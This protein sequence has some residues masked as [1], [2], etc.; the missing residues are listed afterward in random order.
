MNLSL[1]RLPRI[2]T[3]MLPLLSA[4][5]GVAGL[6]LRLLYAAIGTDDAGLLIPGHP[7]WICVCL[8]SVAAAAIAVLG[9]LPIRGPAA[10]RACF[11]RS[12]SG[13]A[14]GVLSGISALA[15]AVTHFRTGAPIF[16]GFLT[17]VLSFLQGAVM[18]L[19]AAA[20]VLTALYRLQGQKP[21]F[22]SHVAICAYF[23]IQMLTLYQ[24]RSFDPQLQEYCFELFACIA[25]TMTAY[26][27]VAFDIGKG[28][29]RRLWAW[30]LAAVYLC[31]LSAASGF[32][33]IAGGIWAF[34]NL[35]NL[36]RP[37]QRKAIGEEI[38][39][40]E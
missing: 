29:H 30:G 26:Q 21:P 14:G 23:A 25:L 33:F 34:T 36:R 9:V 10:Y 37:R 17:P 12:V 35:S 3:R 20:L 13:A 22:L 7:A 31:C 1:S 39:T 2:R 5:C 27:L 16:P 32:F 6:L 4:A 18:V 15:A 40:G 38:P 11:P 24:A 28:S 8:V 19:A